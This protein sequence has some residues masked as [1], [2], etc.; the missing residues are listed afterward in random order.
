MQV[1][2]QLRNVE[3]YDFATFKVHLERM[4]ITFSRPF[5][6]CLPYAARKN[7][8]SLDHTYV[9]LLHFQLRSDGEKDREGR[10]EMHKYAVLRQ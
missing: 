7:D 9:V 4:H 2:Q 6:R 1:V 3:T 5:V 8:F 10:R